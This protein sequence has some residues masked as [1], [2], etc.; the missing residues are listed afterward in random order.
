MQRLQRSQIDTYVAR[1]RITD[2]D[3]SNDVA[4]IVEDVRRRGEQAVREHSE[5][6]GD[7][8]SG[9][10]I[11]ALPEDLE[12][13]SLRVGGET[14][15]L[16]TRT[17]GRIE[18]FA[19][20]QRDALSDISIDVDGGQ[21]GHRWTPIAT[22]GAYAPGG[23]YPLP[24]S[25]LMTVVPARVA[26]VS[27]IWLA[28]PRAT[29]VTL[30]AAHVAGADACVLA[31]GAQAIAALAFGVFGPRCDMVVGP[32]NRWV[33]AAKK[34]LFGE[35]GIEGL[36]GPSE[37]LVLADQSADAELVAA[38]LLAQA[39]HDD[40]AVPMLVTTS[41]QLADEVER[42]MAIQVA[43][44]STADTARAACSNG[45]IYVASSRSEA[46]EISDEVAPEHL[47][48]HMADA[49]AVLSDA[50]SFGSAFV[51]R[52][53]AEAFADYGAGPN[54]VLPTAGGARFQAGLSPM[55]FLRASTWLRLDEPDRLIAD[56]SALAELEG[57]DA[58]KRAA[59]LRTGQGSVGDQS[60]L[61]AMS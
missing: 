40:D 6:F 25:V 39:E 11:V 61:T 5:R 14:L 7:I 23:R 26:G 55:S 10:P 47:A 48:I 2:V 33:T 37:I 28:S 58:H 18:L 53:S 17:S 3:T 29:D 45:F 60:R 16:L 51:G 59:L 21:A 41:E 24:S 44:L 19:Q 32:G 4:T 12:A 42:Q 54:H 50:T 22:A 31:G 13:A 30:A 36:A 1:R 56:T 52:A 46:I 38:D 35:I 49:D 43:W 20:A 57:L 15:D 8:A 9:E 27:S 34:H